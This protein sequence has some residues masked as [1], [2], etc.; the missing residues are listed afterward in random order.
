MLGWWILAVVLGGCG[1]ADPAPADDG[2]VDGFPKTG[3]TPGAVE[4]QGVGPGG[5]T[6]SVAR[7]RQA[8]TPDHRWIRCELPAD[9]PRDGAL[10]AVMLEPDEVWLFAPDAR[11]GWF[12]A[13]VTRPNGSA[14][15]L[16]DGKVVARASWTGAERSAWAA[17]TVS[18]VP[19]YELLGVVIDDQGK[20]IPRAL[21]RGCEDGVLVEANAEGRFSYEAPASHPCGLIAI[22]KDDD[23]VGRSERN[24]F[25]SAEGTVI[26]EL[27]VPATRLAEEE[28]DEQAKRMGGLLERTTRNGV[29]QE[30]EILRTLI[31]RAELDAEARTVTTTWERDLKAR[32]DLAEEQVRRLSTD[33]ADGLLHLWKTEIW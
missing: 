23:G 17:C 26:A 28:A 18:E 13:S 9:F 19:R 21:V 4:V 7:A 11:D 27:Q 1:G 30:L 25:Q 15:V 2:A 6:A 5:V 32:V 31:G 22:V 33:G 16:R 8:V 12:S 3:N 29:G 10:A 20:P 14:L 24:V